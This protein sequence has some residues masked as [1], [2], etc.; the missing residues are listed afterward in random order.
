MNIQPS[1][2]EFDG[3]YNY[4]SRKHIL[5]WNL[6]I[7]DVNNKAGSLEFSVAASIPADFF[8]LQVNRPN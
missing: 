1:V 3:S 4:D 5:E 6:P 7:I 2:G 8:P